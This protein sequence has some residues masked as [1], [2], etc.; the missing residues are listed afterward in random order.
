VDRCDRGGRHARK[1][2]V[3]GKMGYAQSPVETTPSGLHWLWSWAFAIPKAAKQAEAAEKFAV[4]ATSKDY[5]KLVSDD[6]GWPR[7]SPGIRKSTCDNSEYQ[8]APFA[9]TTLQ[10]LQSADPCG[11]GRKGRG[12]GLKQ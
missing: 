7:V 9:A 6:I 8:K 1:S 5:I 10:A 12:F 11:Q 4:W 3:A 2:Q